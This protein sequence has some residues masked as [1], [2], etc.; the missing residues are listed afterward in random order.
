MDY[1]TDEYNISNYKKYLIHA[2][3]NPKTEF[4]QFFGEYKNT[5]FKFNINNINLWLENRES[6]LNNLLLLIHFTSGAP[7]RGSELPLIIIKNTINNDRSIYFDE[8]SK[9]LLFN[10]LYSKLT[11]AARKE[12]YNLRYLAPDISELLIYYLIYLYPFYLFLK[13]ETTKLIPNKL[14]ENQHILFNSEYLFEF[15]NKII[16]SEKFSDLLRVERYI[17][18]LTRLI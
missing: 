6:F 10:T 13:I 17:Y 1:I 7:L 12:K 9:L 3:Y 4:S 16:T 5:K 11:A 8:I 14:K 15:N 2:L 18:L